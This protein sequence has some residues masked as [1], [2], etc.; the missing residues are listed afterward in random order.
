MS[1][2]FFPDGR[3]QAP[4]RSSARRNRRFEALADGR[5]GLRANLDA[6]AATRE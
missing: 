4:M 6:V 3:A 2:L 1:D 5:A